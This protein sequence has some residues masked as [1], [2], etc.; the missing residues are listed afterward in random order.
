MNMR[1]ASID[2]QDGR[3]C[4]ITT[5]TGKK[6]TA[7][8][9]ISNAGIRQTVLKLV[10]EDKFETNYIEKSKHWKATSLAW[11]IAILQAVRYYPIP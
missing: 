4:G 8:I 2:T 6:Y 7:P 9:V 3:V 10:G 5:Q 1:V 11:V